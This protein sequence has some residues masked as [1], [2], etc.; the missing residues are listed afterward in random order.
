MV[1]IVTISGYLVTAKMMNKK[2]DHNFYD[3]GN[4]L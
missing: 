1:S 4:T 2:L 3:K